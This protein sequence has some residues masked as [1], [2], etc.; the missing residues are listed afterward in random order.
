LTSDAPHIIPT[1]PCLD[2]F[3]MGWLH[4]VF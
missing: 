3:C 4:G 1:L 2:L